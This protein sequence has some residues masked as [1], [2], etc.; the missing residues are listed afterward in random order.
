MSMFRS[1]ASAMPCASLWAVGPA[2]AQVPRPSDIVAAE[3]L[4]GWRT[5]QGTIMAALH[6]RLAR[7]WITYWRHP[8]E[9]GIAPRL[10]LSGSGNLAEARVHWPAP[11]LFTKAGF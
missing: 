4:P 8:G 3:V 1:L 9:S 10:D 11:R 5:E 6:L 7:D 2:T